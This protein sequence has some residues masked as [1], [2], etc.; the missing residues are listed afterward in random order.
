MKPIRNVSFFARSTLLSAAL[1]L[2][3]ACAHAGPQT[4]FV[5]FDGAGNLSVFSASSGG[6]VGSIDQTPPPLVPQPLS[7]VSVVLFELDAL[8][9]T[10]SGSFEFTTTDLSATLTGLLSG[11]YSS[12]DI[13]TQG[14]QFSL[15]YTITGGTGDFSSASGYGLAFLNFDPN[16]GFNNYAESGLLN[17]TVPEPGSIALAATGLL[18]LAA[19]RR[20]RGAVVAP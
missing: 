6:W 2:A 5:P 12:V 11:S 8:T 18:A 15:D 1:V 17:V 20:R 9:L 14:G 3:S 19:V 16:G 13:L 7:L 4:Y 10:L